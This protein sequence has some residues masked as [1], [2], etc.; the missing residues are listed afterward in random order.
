MDRLHA[1][2]PF[3]DDARRAVTEANVD[4]ETVVSGDQRPVVDHAIARI[5]GA[6]EQGRVPDPIVDTR[7]EVLSYP[8]ARILI[9]IV[10]E[11]VLTDRYA[12]AEARRAR[13]LFAA[14]RRGE[15]SSRT[16][17]PV[18][19]LLEE[20]DLAVETDAGRHGY[21]VPVT[22]FLSLTDELRDPRWDLVQR[23]LAHGVVPVR[24]VEL[25]TL[26][27]EAIRLRILE[28]LPLTVP[29]QL[30]EALEGELSHIEELL[31]DVELPEAIDRADPAAFP[32]CLDA[33]VDRFRAGENLA[34]PVRF[35]LFSF[36]AAI[37]MTAEDI[38][39]LLEP[40]S[41]NEAEAIRTE[42][43]AIHGGH[44]ATAYP[45]PSCETVSSLGGCS[46]YPTGCD[47]YDHPLVAYAA[48]LE[49]STDR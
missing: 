43:R 19:R 10:D 33:L 44:E 37:G 24:S 21:L 26:L 7:V 17:V 29:D 27:Q 18:D 4:L 47:P 40:G 42:V 5:E 23:E 46:A 38:V 14:D 12:L 20:L 30:R 22:R 16:S 3:L 48:E 35:T 34:S 8:V 2:F 36:L 28:D 6:I 39:D 15:G 11:P 32:P 49:G 25:E 9:S 13:E 45:P 41:E 31:A 1:R